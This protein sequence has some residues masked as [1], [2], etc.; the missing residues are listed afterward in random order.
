MKAAW[1]ALRCGPQEPCTERGHE[2]AFT[3]LGNQ[4]LAQRFVL[5]DQLLAANGRGFS[6]GWRDFVGDLNPLG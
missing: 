3:W 6:S 1:K 2:R 4:L 5:R